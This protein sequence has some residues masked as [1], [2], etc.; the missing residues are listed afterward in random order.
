MEKEIQE[1]IKKVDDKELINW[2]IG[3]LHYEGL[4]E[5]SWAVYLEALSRGGE[6]SEKAVW[7][8]NH[9]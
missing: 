2:L 6:T 4:P 1:K 3:L 8:W 5:E 7:C 9:I